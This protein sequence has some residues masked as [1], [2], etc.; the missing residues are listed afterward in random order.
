MLNHVFSTVFSNVILIK[1]HYD[2]DG[3]VIQWRG[4]LIPSYSLACK[5]RLVDLRMH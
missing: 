3:Y 2:A 1:P 4:S 5:C